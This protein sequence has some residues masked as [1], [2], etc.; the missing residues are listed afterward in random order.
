MKRP[1]TLYLGRKKGIAV[2]LR[3]TGLAKVVDSELKDTFVTFLYFQVPHKYPRV[4]VQNSLN[5]LPQ[6]GSGGL[7]RHRHSRRLLL[8]PPPPPPPCW[9][10]QVYTR[11][12]KR[13][14]GWS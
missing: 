9:Q 11:K 10:G 14:L 7:S 3:N 5:F 1:P 4:S 6:K 8:P 13:G 2:G 12:G